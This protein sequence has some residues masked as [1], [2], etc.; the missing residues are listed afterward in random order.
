MYRSRTPTE[1]EITSPEASSQRF[2]KTRE[3]VQAQIAELSPESQTT[4][5]AQA[6][7]PGTSLEGNTTQ[8]SLTI[9]KKY[10]PEVWHHWRS[11]DL[12]MLIK[13]R[14]GHEW[15]LSSTPL[16]R[17]LNAK[18]FCAA[19]GKST[20][21][22]T[23]YVVLYNNGGQ[24]GSQHHRP[25]SP[26]DHRKVEDM[27]CQGHIRFRHAIQ[28]TTGTRCALSPSEFRSLVPTLPVFQ[29]D[30]VWIIPFAAQLEWVMS[31]TSSSRLHL[32]RFQDPP[33]QR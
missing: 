20:G 21:R 33:R 1:I 3:A 4:T 14:K 12:P 18:V 25:P 32:G 29:S 2:Q 16:H 15:I 31:L 24:L 11:V 19:H 22:A 13:S 30:S 17:L 5:E 6:I 26:L 10:S 9:K 23:A 8:V 28:P 7:S 27:P